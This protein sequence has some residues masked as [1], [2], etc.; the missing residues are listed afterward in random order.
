MFSMNRLS[1]ERRAQILAMLTEGNSMRHSPHGRMRL[2]R[3]KQIVVG[4]RGRLHRVPRP[5]TA[6][7]A[8]H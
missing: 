5:H 7:P 3:S 2:Q 1:I 4:H 8:L 6:R